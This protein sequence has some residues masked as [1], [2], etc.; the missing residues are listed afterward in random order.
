MTVQIANALQTGAPLAMDDLACARDHYR[1]LADMLLVSGP[2]FASMRGEAVKRH[3]QAVQRIREDRE[4]ERA[5]AQA[6]RD[7]DLVEIA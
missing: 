6:E 2:L 4:R 1:L 3:N 5:R 7:A